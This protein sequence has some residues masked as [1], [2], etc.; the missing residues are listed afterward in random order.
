MSQ[1]GRGV[2]GFRRFKKFLIKDRG[3]F[4]SKKNSAAQH[5]LSTDLTERCVYRR[6]CWGNTCMVLSQYQLYKKVTE[7]NSLFRF[8]FIFRGF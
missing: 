6:R 5:V 7:N 2:S 4:N 3:S 1:G 8:L